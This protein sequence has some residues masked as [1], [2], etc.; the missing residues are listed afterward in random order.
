MQKIDGVSYCEYP[1]LSIHRSDLLETEVRRR[2]RFEKFQQPAGVASVKEN[3][4]EEIFLNFILGFYSLLKKRSSVKYY[5]RQIIEL[6]PRFLQKKLFHLVHR[7]LS[8]KNRGT[9]RNVS[10]HE[11]SGSQPWNSDFGLLTSKNPQVT[12]VIPFFD[13]L[14]LTL[15]CLRKLQE[16]DDKIQYDILLVDDG[17]NEKTKSL[18]RGVRGVRYLEISRNVGYLTAMNI[19]MSSF[20]AEYVVLLNNDCL[21]MNGWLDELFR[22]SQEN[23][24]GLIVG[25]TLLFQDGLLQESGSQIF[26]DGSARNIGHSENYDKEIYT[27]VREVDYC[28]FASVLIPRSIWLELGGFDNR[29]SPAYYEDVDFCLSAWTQGYRVL[30]APQSRVIHHLSQSYSNDSQKTEIMQR[31]RGELVKKWNLAEMPIWPSQTSS[32]IEALRESKGIVVVIDGVLPD[33]KRDAGSQRT[34]AIIKNLQELGFHVILSALNP[35][36][37]IIQIKRLQDSGVEV[38]TQSSQLQIY[39]SS[40]SNRIKHFW[41]IRSHIIENFETVCRNIAPMANIIYDVMD[42]AYDQTDSQIKLDRFDR[43]L[44]ANSSNVIVLCSPYELEL[45]L[46]ENQDAKIE[47]LFMP[48][49]PRTLGNNF[50]VRSGILFVGGFTHTPNLVSMQWF[51]SEVLP[52]LRKSGFNDQINIVGAGL[53]EDEKNYFQSLGLIVHGKIDE[54]DE[55]YFSNRLSIAPLTVGR[56]LKGKILESMS[57]GLPVV[58]TSIGAEGFPI[59][60]ELPFIIANSPE[61]FSKSILRLYGDEIL[62]TDLQASSFSFLRKN[63][64]KQNISSRI[65]H[66]LNYNSTKINLSDEFS[67]LNHDY[68]LGKENSWWRSLLIFKHHYFENLIKPTLEGITPVQTNIENKFIKIRRTRKISLYLFEVSKED[69][70][71]FRNIAIKKKSTETSLQGIFVPNDQKSIY[72]HWIIDTLPVYFFLCKLYDADLK[73]FVSGE[74]P[75]FIYEI[76]SLFKIPAET[77]IIL[78][79]LREGEKFVTLRSSPIRDFDFYD[80]QN[81]KIFSASRFELAKFNALSLTSC[82]TF[83]KIFVSRA[84]LP[85]WGPNSRTCENRVE[86]EEYFSSRGFHIIH[87]ESLAVSDQIRLFSSATIIAGEAG[88]GMH[89][90]LFAT[91]STKFINIQSSRQEHL[92]QAALGALNNQITHYFWA[93]N[94]TDDWNSN[95]IVDLEKLDDFMNNL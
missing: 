73:I 53:K 3:R 67:I 65:N 4:L 86:L 63:Y 6:S 76:L 58:T 36:T 48:I 46:T 13:K 82:A 61:D 1:A 47:S 42:L 75:T 34:L 51:A 71:V 10:P 28:S 68:K 29:Y 91:Q 18:L 20:S 92:I 66:I 37:S 87:P 35:T 39:L 45:A 19:A 62:W 89:N 25:S 30:V 70:K 59:S 12:I 60:G 23:Q 94:T 85:K 38:Y 7:S 5:V 90:S 88:S 52:L 32:R 16:N 93:P 72:G 33:G 17:S 9:I 95:F 26:A 11:I 8:F 77:V 2:H 79:N 54:L 43:N 69:E 41:L 15:A 31:S 50:K 84:N 81:F 56:G 55:V 57:F 24:G 22:I 80:L 27:F 40:R 78:D 83:D 74:V 14:E 21:P 44:I 64:S 49:I